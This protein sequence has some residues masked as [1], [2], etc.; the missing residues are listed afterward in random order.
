L[1][2]LAKVAVGQKEKKSAA[3]RTAQ[4]QKMQA[5]KD[6]MIMRQ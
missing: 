2:G 4:L 6:E 3:D 1:S 5:A